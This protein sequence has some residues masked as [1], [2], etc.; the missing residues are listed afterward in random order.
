MTTYLDITFDAKT[1]RWVSAD[2]G[3]RAG[4]VGS[5]EAVAMA[6]GAAISHGARMTDGNLR[7]LAGRCAG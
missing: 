2:F 6:G 3:V 7:A 1:A 4:R 5:P